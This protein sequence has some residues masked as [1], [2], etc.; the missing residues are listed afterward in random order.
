MTSPR[1]YEVSGKT[2]VFN[3]QEPQ[4][5]TFSRTGTL[6]SRL[7][8]AVALGAL[9]FMSAGAQA[10]AP[11]EITV[12]APNVKTV[13][14]DEATGAPIQD[15]TENASIKYDPVT[16][17]TNSGV[18]LLKDSVL[19]AALKV[20]N[21]ITFSMSDEDDGTCVRDAVKSA[22]TQVDAA[23]ARARSTANG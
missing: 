13:G 22:Q 12:S 11:D 15:I 20:C 1:L 2:A 4:M 8:A 19:E 10:A 16:L 6:R 14:R 5:I 3:L 18:A 23:V 7:S 17:T 9:A 21:S